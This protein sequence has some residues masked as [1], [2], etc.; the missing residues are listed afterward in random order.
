MRFAQDHVAGDI[1]TPSQGLS[2]VWGN[3]DML[4]CH[5]E[6]DYLLLVITDGHLPTFRLCPH[7]T[8]LR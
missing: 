8:G 1:I 4:A 3:C 6:F 2:L 7:S 5:K